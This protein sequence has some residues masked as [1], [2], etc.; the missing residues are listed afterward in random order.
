MKVLIV[1]A[2]PAGLMAAWS[3]AKKGNDVIVIEKNEKAGKKIYITGKGRCNVTNKC[4][5]EEW[6]N[7]IVSN[8]KFLY[9]AYAH[10]NCDDTM[11]FF[12]D[13]GVALVVERGNRVFPQSYKASDITKALKKKCADSNV[14]INYLET[15]LDIK[16]EEEKFV[17]RTDRQV[18]KADK[19]LITTG[20]KSYPLTGSTGDGYTFAK[21]FGH[22]IVPLV[23]GLNGIKIKDNLPSD[24]F[25]L[26]LKNVTLKVK[27][28]KKEIQEFGELTF[29]N[30]LL[31]GPISLTVS[32]LINRK[33]KEDVSISLDL[34]PALN[35]EKLDA[36]ILRDILKLK[37]E[38]VPSLL[39]GLLPAPMVKYFAK[40]AK[41]DLEKQCNSITQ[42]ERKRIVS[43]LKNFPLT[44]DGIDVLDKAI[45]TAGGVNVKEVN[46]KTMESKL[47][48]GLYFAGEVL[49]LDAFTG[50]F[51][52]QI[53][54]STGKLAGDSM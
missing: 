40:I 49:D 6:M 18:H 43:L 38:K 15:V 47:V 45:I 25:N 22:T 32:S 16:K 21:R 27:C 48:S 13:L 41:L 9:S 50:G 11:K 26:G 7:N 44:Y 53:A 8:P 24:M 12:E 23:P 30:H 20:G 29:L 42:V 1:G 2:G 46:A 52:M 36:R 33:N 34:K 5:Q 51:N 19:V 35:E 39:R 37:I 4:S 3:S 14:E 31:E 54:F 28:G 10:F 17:V